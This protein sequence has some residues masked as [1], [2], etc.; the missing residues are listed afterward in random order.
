MIEKARD[1]FSRVPTLAALFKEILACQGLSTVLNVLFVTKLKQEMP[2]DLGRAGYMGKVGHFDL[3]QRK[4]S[5]N[6]LSNLYFSS[7][8][9]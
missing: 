4:Y 1:V 5:N 7:L 6:A 2:D 8:G 3:F 9:G